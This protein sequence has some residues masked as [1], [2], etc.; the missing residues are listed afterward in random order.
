MNMLKEVY[1][2]ARFLTQTTTGVQRFAIEIAKKTIHLV[3]KWIVINLKQYIFMHT[4]LIESEKFSHHS[5]KHHK[6]SFYQLF[7]L[8]L[9]QLLY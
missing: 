2:N 3:Y 5:N 9:F 8:E 6:A 7:H 4:S 1:I